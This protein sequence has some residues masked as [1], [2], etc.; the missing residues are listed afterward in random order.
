MS[1]ESLFNDF[2]KVNILLDTTLETGDSLEETIYKSR[3]LSDYWR[4]L[5]KLYKHKKRLQF[6]SSIT[7]GGSLINVE[8]YSKM[9]ILYEKMIFF[10]LFLNS[11]KEKTKLN[12]GEI[13]LV[14]RMLSLLLIEI[15]N[16]DED[17]L[18][19]RHI[20]T[21]YFQN[22]ADLIKV[23]MPEVDLTDLLNAYNDMYMHWEL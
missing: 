5:S 3:F 9:I 8:Y 6:L 17:I 1:K 23:E 4:N 10:V 21:S 15:D 12:E 13:H 14:R 20:P 11:L 16:I 7:R 18:P 22:L 19:R 2:E